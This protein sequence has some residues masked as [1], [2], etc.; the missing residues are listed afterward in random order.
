MKRLTPILTLVVVAIAAVTL[1]SCDDAGED[2][3]SQQLLAEREARAEAESQ[4]TEESRLRRRW[5]L[6]AAGMVI[7]AIVGFVAGTA[8]GSRG[9]RHHEASA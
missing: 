5:E 4:A 3:T 7:I 9:R 6:T 8:L 1:T 2:T